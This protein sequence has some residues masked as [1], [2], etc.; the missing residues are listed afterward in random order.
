[1]A[2]DRASLVAACLAALLVAGAVS[3]SAGEDG[4]RGLE[5]DQISTTTDRA[6]KIRALLQDVSTSTDT[7]VAFAT[8]ADTAG[9]D[10]GTATDTQTGTDTGTGTDTVEDTEPPVCSPS[11]PADVPCIRRQPPRCSSRIPANVPCIRS[12]TTSTSRPLSTSSR[13]STG[14]R[15][16]G[17]QAGGARFGD[18]PTL[19]GRIVEYI[20]GIQARPRP[21]LGERLARLAGGVGS[22][23]R[24]TADV[25]D[26]IGRFGGD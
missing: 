19:G 20:T 17:A 22:V 7:S 24:T 18:V 1:M 21:P 6:L 13:L 10:P 2:R 9:T 3:V 4:P 12:T 8:S 5:A 15:F 23:V 16:T 11:I 25:L 26:I 14:S